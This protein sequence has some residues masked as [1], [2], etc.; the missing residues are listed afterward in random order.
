MYRAVTV[1]PALQA[2]R[3]I[4]PGSKPASPAKNPSPPT[5][6]GKTTIHIQPNQD[7]LKH[8]KSSD[9]TKTHHTPNSREAPAMIPISFDYSIHSP[10][11]KEPQ[12]ASPHLSSQQ[13]GQ[14]TPRG[15][16]KATPTTNNLGVHNPG[17]GTK[18][19]TEQKKSG[20]HIEERFTDYIHRAKI[21]IRTTSNVGDKKKYSGNER[22]TDYIR[23]A[24]AKIRTTT[25]STD[26]ILSGVG[27]ELNDSCSFQ[28]KIHSSP[29]PLPPPTSSSSPASFLL[30]LLLFPRLLLLL[31][32]PIRFQQ[33]PFPSLSPF[34]L[35]PQKTINGKSQTING[36]TT[37]PSPGTIFFSGVGKSGFVANKLSQ[38]L[39]SLSIRSSF[40]PSTPSTATSAPSPPST[41]SSSAS[42][43]ALRSSSALSPTSWPRAPTSSY[44]LSLDWWFSVG[45]WLD[46]GGGGCEEEEVGGG[47]C[48]G[49]EARR[50]LWLWGR[51]NRGSARRLGWLAA[52][53]P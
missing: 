19:V 21:K 41:S 2:I 31:L 5:H 26:N 51:R 4:S 22:F 42:P 8:H 29:P 34:T 47:L 16:P 48:G 15:K 46:G 37:T 40:S 14:V 11:K 18:V 33:N 45:K 44:L 50:V 32:V 17:Q 23:R 49:E 9:G 38:T 43:E 20:M 6:P 27:W 39:T 25:R 3:R 53:G 13:N 30:L 12:S 28:L 7:S 35:L 10:L 36:K 52:G 24:G 1:C